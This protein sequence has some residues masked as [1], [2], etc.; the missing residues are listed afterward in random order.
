MSKMTTFEW[1]QDCLSFTD[2]TV[3]F[4]VII[5]VFLKSNRIISFKK[6]KQALNE[7]QSVQSSW[8]YLKCL[9]P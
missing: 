3:F 8:T 6:I 7:G 2:L 4:M 9:I 1:S 5:T